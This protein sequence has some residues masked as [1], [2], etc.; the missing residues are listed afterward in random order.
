[1][2]A[3]LAHP[4]AH[5][6]DSHSRAADRG[7]EATQVI[8][9]NALAV[10]AHFEFEVIGVAFE[11]DACSRRSG[12]AMNIGKAFLQNP[13]QD[14]FTV[15]GRALHSF[16]DIAIDLNSAAA[17]KSLDKPTSGGSD[18]GFIEQGRMQQVRGGANFLQGL[19][20]QCIQIIN[21]VRKI[22]PAH[23]NLAD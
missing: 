3:Q 13:E 6:G 5:A 8:F 17:G 11:T 19:I 10:V 21:Q 18:A 23:V 4:F 20:G 7:V 1:M 15:S 2:A 12:M 16:R 9:G 14:E 22:G